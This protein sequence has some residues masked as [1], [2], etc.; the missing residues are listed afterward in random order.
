MS[1]LDQYGPA[2]I[3]AMVNVSD[4]VTVIGADGRIEYVNPAGLQ[5]FGYETT[6]ALVG[7]FVLDHIHPDDLPRVVV[8]MARML[9]VDAEVPGRPAQLR[10]RRADGTYV[11]IEANGASGK[12]G[13]G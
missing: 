3:G 1:E 11:R 5:V 9:E 10:I 13:G 6:E 2:L 4:L 7:T 12:E 8:A